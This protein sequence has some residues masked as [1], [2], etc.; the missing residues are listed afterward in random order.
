MTNKLDVIITC[1]NR[2]KE[3]GRAISSVA[4]QT[5]REINKIIIVDDKSE[6]NSLGIIDKYAEIYKNLNFQIIKHSENR[7]QNA[8]INT[9]LKYSDA[10]YVSFLDSDDIWDPEFLSTLV[11]KFNENIDLVYCWVKNGP[12]SYL[13]SDTNYKDVLMQG[14]LSNMI[15]FVVKRKSLEGGDFFDEKFKIQACLH[16]LNKILGYLVVFDNKFIR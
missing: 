4:W 10:E 8:A 3:I 6:D 12:R 1:Y 16:N 14:Y 15:T 2:E 13:G 7:G 9:G 5:Y 11:S